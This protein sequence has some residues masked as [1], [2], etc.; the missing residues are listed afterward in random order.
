MIDST[1]VLCPENLFSRKSEKY[2]VA[3]PT[4]WTYDICAAD[5]GTYCDYYWPHHDNSNDVNKKHKLSITGNKYFM[6]LCHKEVKSGDC[7]T[8]WLTKAVTYL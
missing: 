8:D 4:A 7:M 2:K 5:T 3:C 6:L 1:N